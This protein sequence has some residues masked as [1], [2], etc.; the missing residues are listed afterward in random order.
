MAID[1]TDRIRAHADV[2]EGGAL[3][4]VRS[5]V[6][7]SDIARVLHEG[8]DVA[9]LKDG[10]RDLAEGLDLDVLLIDT[11]PG[12]N[13]ETLLSIMISDALILILRPDRQDF[14]G[15]AVTVGVARRLKVP[16]LMLVLNMVPSGVDLEHLAA[17]MAAN[18]D[19]ETVAVMPLSEDVVRNASGD[20]FSLV[21]PTHEW[22]Q[23]LRAIADRLAS[24]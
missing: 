8:Y 16:N 12:L 21:E 19:A 11:H 18:Y 14:E 24:A 10:F 5:S 13:E 9:R 4:L 15:T 6:N 17:E 23:Q 3:H 2:P 1:V 22:S 20:L 7:A